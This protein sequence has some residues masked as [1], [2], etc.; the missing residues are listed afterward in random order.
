MTS[1]ATNI[2]TDACPYGSGAHPYLT[3]GTDTVDTVLLRAPGRTVLRADARGIPIGAAPVQGTEY[4]F[5]RPRAIGAIKLDNAFTDFERDDDGLARVEL[6]HPDGGTTL[7]LWL[8][9]S[10][11][12]VALIGASTRLFGAVWACRPS[13]GILKTIGAAVLGASGSSRAYRVH[14]GRPASRS[15]GAAVLRALVRDVVDRTLALAA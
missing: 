10:Y 4:D 5:R 9:D 7:S 6:R 11:P 12:W 3:V 15:R 8:G 14:H 1:T 2:G 13:C